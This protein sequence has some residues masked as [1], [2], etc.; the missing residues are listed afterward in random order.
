MVVSAAE[1]VK[2]PSRREPRGGGGFFASPVQRLA[3]V[4]GR[5]VEQERK[6]QRLIGHN[7]SPLQGRAD[8]ERLPQVRAIPQPSKRRAD[9]IDLENQ[10]AQAL[11]ILDAIPTE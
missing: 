10:V 6:L 9:L 1:P 8:G 11:A 5:L 2:S 3:R 4:T 7:E